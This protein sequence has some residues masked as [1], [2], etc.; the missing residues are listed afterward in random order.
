[1]LSVLVRSRDESS[2]ITRVVS[3]DG[4]EDCPRDLPKPGDRLGHNRSAVKPDVAG[5]DAVAVDTH[6]LA[7]PHCFITEGADGLIDSELIDSEWCA[8]VS[9]AL[10]PHQGDVL[11]AR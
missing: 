1:M 9:A 5:T 6:P 8:A 7:A 11:P 10:T 4:W 2:Q 3:G